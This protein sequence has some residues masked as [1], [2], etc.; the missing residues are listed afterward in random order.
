MWAYTSQSMEFAL[1]PERLGVPAGANFSGQSVAEPGG[2]SYTV[3]LTVSSAGIITDCGFTYEGSAS[4][5]ASASALMVLA[6]GRHVS[7]AAAINEGLIESVLGCLPE[8][9]SGTPVYALDALRSACHRWLSANGGDAVVC[10]CH[11]LT[12][13]HVAVSA[14]SGA[15]DV[16]TLFKS[17]IGFVPSDCNDCMAQL[18]NML[19]L[20]RAAFVLEQQRSERER[21]VLSRLSPAQRAKWEAIEDVLEREV[22]PG[23]A[24]DGGGIELKSVEGNQVVVTLLGACRSC[25]SNQTTMR[26]F[27]EDKLREHVDPGIELTDDNA[28]PTR[29]ALL[30]ART[31]R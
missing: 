30:A 8:A 6:R 20:E 22:R 9:A 7:A 4:G 23:L 24:L 2:T 21:A 10:A 17:T 27:I 14:R 18:A 25:A 28:P 19:N 26:F 29:D 15:N 5:A 1:A 11:G 3:H 12:R 13:G 31:P 16:G